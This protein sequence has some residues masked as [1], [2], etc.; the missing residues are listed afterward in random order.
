MDER[1]AAIAAGTAP[2]LVWLLE[3]PPLYTAG[4]SAKPRGPDRGALSRP[5][6]P[7]AAASSPITA[8]ASAWPM[9]CSTSSAASP[10]C[11]RFVATLGGMDHPHACGLQRQRR[12]ARRPHRRLGAPAGQGRGPRRQDRRHRRPDASAGSRS[13]ALRST[14]M[15][16][17]SHFSGIVPCGVSDRA[18]ASPASPISASG[19]DGRGR[20]VLRREFEQLFGPL[21]RSH[22]AADSLV[23]SL[24]ANALS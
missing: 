11:A 10:T 3:H 13:M 5:S 19:V 24:P 17:L 22:A 7:A 21:D 20:R 8:P 18:T 15:P 12:A 1:V 14:S 2:E 6:R 9:S 16:D 4:T 23:P